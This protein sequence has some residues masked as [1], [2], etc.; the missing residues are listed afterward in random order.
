V[1]S[2]MAVLT[3]CW[4]AS[5]ESRQNWAHVRSY[6]YQG[7]GASGAAHASASAIATTHAVAHAVFYGGNS[8][9][10]ESPTRPVVRA[11]NRC[12]VSQ[13]RRSRGVMEPSQIAVPPIHGRHLL[14][15]LRRK[16]C[17]RACGLASG[18]SRL[19]LP[20]RHRS[21]AS[22]ER[23]SGREAAW[24]SERE[25]R[26]ARVAPSSPSGGRGQGA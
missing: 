15:G 5:I 25:T 2:R 7:V 10:W 26:E 14:G 11:D 1:S 17:L 24:R 6:G 16:L 12:G 9:V 13:R 23:R 21:P 4:W 3:A 22:A 8:S 18:P 20:G 19:R